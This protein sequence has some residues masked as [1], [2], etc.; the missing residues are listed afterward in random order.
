MSNLLPREGVFKFKELL[1]KNFKLII[2]LGVILLGL[3]ALLGYKFGK[4]TSSSIIKPKPREERVL[5][6]VEVNR[7]F[8]FKGYDGEGKPRG[9]LGFTITTVE[10]ENQIVVK[11]KPINPQKG[12]LFL[13]VNIELQNDNPRSLG[14]SSRNLVRLID[15]E[16]KKYAPSFYNKGVVIAPESVKKDKIGFVVEAKEKSFRLQVGEPAREKEIIE[17]QF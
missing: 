11:G 16:G 5:A 6:S 8:F 13:S 17:I 7:S 4:R 1:R 3:G 15:G 14:I 9:T 2:F 10:K 12:K